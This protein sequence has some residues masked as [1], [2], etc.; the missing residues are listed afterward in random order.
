MNGYVNKSS[1]FTEV[2]PII[3]VQGAQ[4]G[5]EAKGAITAALALEREADIVVR[6]GTVNAGH[7]VYYDGQPFAMQQLPVGW[8]RPSTRLYLGPGAYI[9]PE[10]L[11]KEIRWIN[12]AT[13]VDP[14]PRIY[15]DYR[16]GLH[17]PAHTD[18]STASDRH[19][20]MGAT[21]K[22]CSEA[23]MAK[24]R[25]R[26]TPDGRLFAQWWS[27]PG[28]IDYQLPAEL[29]PWLDNLQ[30]VDTVSELNYSWDQGAKIIIEGT[31]GT[32]LDL[33]TGPYPYTT[34][35]QTAPGNWV[36][37]AGLSPSLPYEVILVARTYP[38][39]VAGNSGPMPREIGWQ[40]LAREINSKLATS[41]REPLVEEWAL[42]EF[43]AACKEITGTY[44]KAVGLNTMVDAEH[45][46]QLEN[47]HQSVRE[48]H[49]GFV[50]GLHAEALIQVGPATLTELRKL[51]EL[52]TVT[53][54]LRR[55]ARLDLEQLKYSVMLN[56]P[57]SL[58]LTFINYE[59]PE[60]WGCGWGDLEEASALR[61]ADYL[62]RLERD[63]GV[64]VRY[65]STG[66]ETKHV[67]G[68]L[69][70]PTAVG[71]GRE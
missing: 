38:I 40:T 58:A 50:S 71:V 43:E 54:K 70:R 35:K 7:T 17:L 32:M 21:G 67:L 59:F 57:K 36:A 27:K 1:R 8:I 29:K 53:K 48:H 64:P 9:H 11:A 68:R 28:I 51:F 69:G 49:R 56:R 60:T 10:I 45:L 15:I 52:T 46:W 12:D 61:M 5:S 6:T 62:A 30:L 3:V 18:L 34:H 24:I 25:D 47:W 42:E 2:Y 39:R 33:H 20:L 4:W 22:G 65:V 26:G 31:Q 16:C 13:G 37:E 19:R 14:R 44:I 63:L 66:P 55:I 41:G 23:V